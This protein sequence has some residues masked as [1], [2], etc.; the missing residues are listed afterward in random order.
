MKDKY[1]IMMENLNAQIEQAQLILDNGGSISED[2]WVR[3]IYT[4]SELHN[5]IDPE[6]PLKF[7]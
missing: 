3:M 6:G 2:R 4:L 5:S 7:I 1:M